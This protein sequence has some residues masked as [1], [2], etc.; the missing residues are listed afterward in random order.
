[1]KC[2]KC[3]EQLPKDSE[4]CEFC[5]EKV[6]KKIKHCKKC[7]SIIDNSTKICTGCGKKYYKG[8]KLNKLSIAIIVLSLLLLTSIII[9]LVQYNEINNLLIQEDDLRIKISGYIGQIY[10]LENEVRD[11]EDKEWENFLKLR[12]FDNHAVIVGD[13]GTRKYHKYD[14]SDL[15]TSDGFWIFNTE[16]AEGQGYYACPKCH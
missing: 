3:G 5:G 4:F 15:D 9:N 6:V 13:D 16:A 1:M 14:C 12:F 2:I 10:D 11:L 8:F 7:G